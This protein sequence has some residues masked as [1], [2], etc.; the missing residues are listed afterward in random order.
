MESIRGFHPET[1]GEQVT[2]EMQLLQDDL[3]EMPKLRQVLSQKA[4]VSEI[5]RLQAEKT[6]KVDSQAQM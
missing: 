1:Y 3:H 6:N 5:S 4:E 2:G